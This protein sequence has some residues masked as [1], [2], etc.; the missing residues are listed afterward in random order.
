MR[1]L[2]Q[3]PHCSAWPPN[4]AVRQRSMADG[5]ALR[6]GQRCAVLWPIGVAVAAEDVRQFRSLAGHGSRRSQGGG[7]QVAVTEQQLDGTPIGPS[8]QQVDGKGGPQRVRWPGLARPDRSRACRQAQSTAR[9]D[10]GRSSCDPG[11]NHSFG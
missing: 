3:A 9:G 7:A 10:I 1:W 11:N 6:A 4:A 2:P 5:A 8:L